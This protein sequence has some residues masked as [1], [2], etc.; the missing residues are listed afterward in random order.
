MLQL[1]YRA[2]S[3]LQFEGVLLPPACTGAYPF[4]SQVII[5]S[6][7]LITSTMVLLS[8]YIRY[9]V[10]PRHR[11][12]VGL[13]G[14]ASVTVALVFYANATFTALSLLLCTTVMMPNSG[15]AVLDGGSTVSS[16][17]RGAVSR[18]NVLVQNPFF[19]CW[20]GNHG[21]AGAAAVTVL[22]FFVVCFPVVLMIWAVR[23]R[24]RR[25]EL[26]NYRRASACSVVRVTEH[27][28]FP[29]SV[30]WGNIFKRPAFS[31]TL[32]VAEAEK[33]THV[34]FANPIRA[35][36]PSTTLKSGLAR[37]GV[38]LSNPHPDTSSSEICF[39]PVLRPLLGDYIPTAWYTKF[40]DLAL[41]LT[42]SLLN[43]L[44]PRPSTLLLIA[45]K[46][47]ISC[48]AQLAACIHVLI[49]RPYIP[50]QNW[51]VYVR[52]MLLVVSICCT[53]LST[54]VFVHQSGLGP[55]S[56]AASNSAGAYVAFALSCIAFGVLIVAF[57]VS[58][59]QGTNACLP[60]YSLKL[61]TS[62]MFVL[63]FTLQVPRQSSGGWIQTMINTP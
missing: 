45:V 46:T 31:A 17:T 14:R 21:G 63:H 25:H 56:L 1:M 30:R 50:E 61:I 33:E 24:H 4:E 55:E 52:A 36:R 49:V 22:M 2:I 32:H 40:V 19:V 11:S 16:T 6:I 15:V 42:L 35:A 59:Y 41:L 53:L 29:R 51:K 28:G 5:M 62:H 27:D 20:S 43:A 10:H 47:S 23:D 3:V 12:M 54:T 7:A 44:I 48:A 9:C 34:S 57:C 60:Q 37:N 58:M 26:V 8:Y 38:P 39:D 13:C 18:V